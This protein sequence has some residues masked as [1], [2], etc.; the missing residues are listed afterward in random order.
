MEEKKKPRLFLYSLLLPTV[1]LSLGWLFGIFFPG[2]RLGA[3]GLVLILYLTVGAISWHFGRTF[4]RQFQVAERFRL[5]VYC[6]VWA[7]CCEMLALVYAASVGL[8][9]N[10][11][12]DALI[13]IIG[14]TAALD[15]AFVWAGFRFLAPRII[16]KFIVSEDESV[17]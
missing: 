2:K 7:V 8:V 1:W 10:V 13:A 12:V 9:K 17:A 15:T 16:T 4:N 11:D 5:V 3:G 6:S 14:M